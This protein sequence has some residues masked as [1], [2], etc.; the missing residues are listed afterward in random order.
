MPDSNRDPDLNRDGGGL[1]TAATEAGYPSWRAPFD[2]S[3]PARVLS[4]MSSGKGFVVLS[5]E[6]GI[7]AELA[8]AIAASLRAAGFATV[9]MSAPLPRLSMLHDAIRDVMTA[10][11]TT[12]RP[13]LVIVRHAQNL[14]TKTLQRLIALAELRQAGRP[15]LRFLLAGTP[16]LW[17]TLRGAG[18][19]GLEDDPA[20]HIRLMLLLPQPEP[21][22]PRPPGPAGAGMA[23][24]TH[25]ERHRPP[26]NDAAL[27]AVP[28]A[29]PSARLP[30][31]RVVR[32][33]A[34]AGVGFTLAGIGLAGAGAA[35]WTHLRPLPD[36]TVVPS[37]GPAGPGQ[38]RAGHSADDRLGVLL[39]RENEEI[40]ASHLWSPP[41]DNLIETG[42]EIDEILPQLSTEALRALSTAATARAGVLTGLTGGTAGP[43]QDRS[44]HAAPA[45]AADGSVGGTQL[46]AA[47]PAGGHELAGAAVHVTLQYSRGDDAAE[48]RAQQMLARL[49]T[50]GIRADGPVPLGQVIDRSSLSYY[51]PKDQQAAGRLA[52]RLLPLTPPVHKLV[53]PD[54]VSLPRLGEIS[55]SVGSRD[56]GAALPDR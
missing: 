44:G 51:F 33:R 17:P 46:A 10:D 52:Q 34:L 16:A 54:G 5:G 3:A 9:A 6:Q 15:V 24:T 43:E 48:A 42:R 23:A 30:E 47:S 27:R 38:P 32:G 28:S 45:D 20:N 37:G 29:G 19:G 41:G 40:A 55:I 39:K 13:L 26:P 49:R 8:A 36:G 22:L 14:S 25:G 21:W 53:L 1:L 2:E 12:E 7:A 56:A 4:A 35:A 50:E 11:M 18:L 31:S